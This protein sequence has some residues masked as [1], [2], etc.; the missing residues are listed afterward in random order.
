VIP[1]ER[2]EL[3]TFRLAGR[4]H[5]EHISIDVIANPVSNTRQHLM[6]KCFIILVFPYLHSITPTSITGFLPGFTA[7]TAM[8]LRPLLRVFAAPGGTY[9]PQ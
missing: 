3:K 5:L 8:T 4:E 9:R 6:V 2:L 1:S 7:L